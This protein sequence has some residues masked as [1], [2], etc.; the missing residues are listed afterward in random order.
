MSL[1]Q[2]TGDLPSDARPDDSGRGALLHG[3]PRP[4][5]ARAGT[6]HRPYWITHRAE[7]RKAVQELAAQK[8]DIVKVWVDDRNGKFKKLTPELYG[9]SIDEAHKHSLRVTA[10]IFTLEDAKGCGGAASTPSRTACAIAT[11]T[12]SSWR[13]SRPRPP[14]CSCRTCPI[15]A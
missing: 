1:G 13:W 7:A 12:T 5:R 9:A 10:H 11:S 14:S 4:H 8:V 2:D 3:R 6:H 15:A